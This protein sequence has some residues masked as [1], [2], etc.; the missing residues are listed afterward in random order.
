MNSENNKTKPLPLRSSYKN[1][2][3]KISK[4]RKVKYDKYIEKKKKDIGLKKN[5]NETLTE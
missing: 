5:W 2:K 4:N 1:R 3:I